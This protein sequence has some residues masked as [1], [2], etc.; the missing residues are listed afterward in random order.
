VFIT[1]LCCISDISFPFRLETDS[2]I[3]VRNQ[4]TAM[5]EKVGRNVWDKWDDYLQNADGDGKS[6]K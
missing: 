5:F 3:P 1:F 6:N 2:S 4:F